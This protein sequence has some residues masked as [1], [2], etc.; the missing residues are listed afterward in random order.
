[1]KDEPFISLFGV[2]LAYILLLGCAYAG[3]TMAWWGFMGMYFFNSA[4]FWV[5]VDELQSPFFMMLLWPYWMAFPWFAE[6]LQG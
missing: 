1:M 5:V 4:L 6:M 2:F 3:L